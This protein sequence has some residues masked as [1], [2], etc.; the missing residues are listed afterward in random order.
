MNVRDAEHTAS[1]LVRRY[2]RKAAEKM[3]N[4]SIAKGLLV[5]EKRREE[6]G[7]QEKLELREWQKWLQFEDP[8]M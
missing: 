2:S 4:N 3:P 8:L 1:G 7:K 5:V 6:Y